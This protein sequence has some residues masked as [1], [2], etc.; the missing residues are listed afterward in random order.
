MTE[1][2][3]TT[4]SLIHNKS[5]LELGC[6]AALPSIVAALLGASHVV[7]TD[8]PDPI[9]LENLQ[10]NLTAYR[11]VLNTRNSSAQ[12]SGMGFLWGESPTEVLECLPKS[13][14]PGFD[15]VVLAD[16]SFNHSEHAKL[17]RSVAATLKRHKDAVA[18]VYFTAYRPWLLD[19]DLALFDR[20][21]EV[22]LVSEKV[23]STIMKNL[24]FDVDLGVSRFACEYCRSC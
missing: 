3:E 9:V 5:L 13:E 18:Y 2:F 10:H 20:L 19:R 1:L 8:Y 6:G 4:P 7:A 24:M 16:V 17:A 14:I 22:G 11:P 21:K 12:L 23:S 15:I